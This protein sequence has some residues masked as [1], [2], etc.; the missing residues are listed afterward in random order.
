[1]DGSDEGQKPT[2]GEVNKKLGELDIKDGKVVLKMLGGSLIFDVNGSF[3]GGEN[4]ID[5]AK[6]GD[7]I[8][9]GLLKLACENEVIFSGRRF[10][11]N[12]EIVVEN[13][14]VEQRLGLVVGRTVDDLEKSK[15]ELRSR[16][17]EVL[18]IERKLAHVS[19]IDENTQVNQEWFTFSL[20]DKRN[21]K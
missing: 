11:E 5:G 14:S 13:P 8:S 1:M 21:N 7:R 3:V 19:Q 15:V 9:E 17:G 2:L 18:K 4:R 12:S 20:E 10:K 6:V 16:A